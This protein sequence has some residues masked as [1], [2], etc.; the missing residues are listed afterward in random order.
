[1]KNEMTYNLSHMHAIENNYKKCVELIEEA[2]NEVDCFYNIFCQEYKGQANI[3]M[4][5]TINLLKNH[6][7]F[8]SES[9]KNTAHYVAMARV[10]MTQS[11]TFLEKI[12][13][14]ANIEVLK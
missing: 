10:K 7:D 1:M 11:D 2:K 8:Y 14:G 3:G 9:C 12:I 6:L 13:W 4:A 5:D